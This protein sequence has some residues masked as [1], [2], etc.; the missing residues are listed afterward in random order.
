MGEATV[1]IT[2]KPITIKVVAA[3]KVFGETDPEFKGSVTGLVKE[4]DLGVVKYVRVGTEEAVGVYTAVLDATY[5]DNP[6]YKVTLKKGD[7]E[8]TK[9]VVTEE[10]SKELGAV[11]PEEDNKVLGAEKPKETSKL[12]ATSISNDAILF[13]T[14]F[15]TALSGL[16]ITSR[17]RRK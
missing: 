1:T 3:S 7:F 8:I 2:P 5:T 12:P 16:Y 15:M 13:G 17:K 11:K 9:V 6:N 10:D 14:T 4:T